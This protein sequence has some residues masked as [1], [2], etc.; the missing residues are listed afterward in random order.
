MELRGDKVFWSF[1]LAFGVFCLV[2]LVSL[3]VLGLQG[4]ALKQPEFHLF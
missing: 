3:T 4:L 2:S 1:F